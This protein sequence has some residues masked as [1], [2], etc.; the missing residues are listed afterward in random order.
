[1]I[2]GDIH[3]LFWIACFVLSICGFQLMVFKV[4]DKLDSNGIS[5]STGTNPIKAEEVSETTICINQRSLFSFED[6]VSGYF[7]H[8][9]NIARIR[10]S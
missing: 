4:F 8:G 2:K 5:I 1:M 9:E 3:R 6:S 10:R 7:I